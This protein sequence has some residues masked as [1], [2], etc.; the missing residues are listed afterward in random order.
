MEH[1]GDRGSREKVPSSFAKKTAVFPA[2]ATVFRI[3]RERKKKRQTAEQK[4]KEQKD[5]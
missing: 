1:K 3:T 2:A 4:G 5:T